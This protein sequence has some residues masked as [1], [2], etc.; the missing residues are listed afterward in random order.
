MGGRDARHRRLALWLPVALVLAILAAAGTAY[1][2]DPDPP[3]D[4]GPAAVPPPPG[5]DLPAVTAPDPVAEEATGT[6]N[7]AKVRRAVAGLL[8]DP[9][10][11]PHVLA[12]VAGLDGTLL[13]SSG[14]GEAAPASTM[15][16]LTTTAA[17]ETLG[18]DHTFATRV[19]ADGARRVV[20]VGGGDPLLSATDLKK[21]A[22]TTAAH[23]DRPVRVGYDAQLFSGPAV[24]PHWEPGYVPEEV[25][26]VSALWVDE[27]ADAADPAAAAAAVFAK[28]LTRAGARVV[29]EPAPAR[30]SANDPELATV[31]SEPLAGI[32][33][34]TL[35]TSDNNAA[36]VLARHVGIAVSGRGSFRAGVA[37]VLDT[38]DALGVPT[39]NAVVYD[40]SGL[41]RHDRLDPDTLTAVLETAGSDEHPGLRSVLTGLPVAAFTGSLE[42]RFG[43]G[44]AGN[45]LVRAK[46]GTLSG[47]S[48]LAGTVVDRNGTPMVF[49]FLAD[50]IDLVDTLDAR[51]ALDDLTSALAACRCGGAGTVAP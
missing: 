13:Y 22:R 36:E 42:Y 40:G 11:G 1:L 33:E 30:A 21:L 8:D 10:L 26:P 12:T 25:S 14:T 17:L 35:L 41:S 45:G 19:V 39:R 32:V 49:A 48:A 7:P 6:P 28:A 50:R 29:G 31:D 51:A 24:N 44:D 23:V 46:T 27:R 4:D 34:H 16:L 15:K 5:L 43:P 38:L 18:P 2:L 37:G 47:V 3:A 9:D 20:L